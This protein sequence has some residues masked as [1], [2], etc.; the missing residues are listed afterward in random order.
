MKPSPM[1]LS[2]YPDHIKTV[3]SQEYIYIQT[4]LD[5][6]RAIIHTPSGA[7]YSRTGNRL[8]LPYITGDVLSC[9]GLPEWLD[10]ELY[11]HGRT[12]GQI[13]SSIKRGTDEIQFHC[14]DIIAGGTFSERFKNIKETDFIKPVHALKIKPVDIMNIYNEYLLAG[15]EGAV[16]RFNAEYKQTRS[17][18]ILKLKPDIY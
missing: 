5:G 13:Q 15:Y 17:T 3:N 7:I 14:F 16:I 8:N 11:V 2:E 12:L 9:H 18:E 10:G 1:L 4:K 6:W